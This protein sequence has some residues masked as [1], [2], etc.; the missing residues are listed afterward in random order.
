VVK[1]WPGTGVDVF[2]YTYGSTQ[3]SSEYQGQ[4]AEIRARYGAYR[5]WLQID[6][7]DEVKKDFSKPLKHS[8][9]G[10]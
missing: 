8:V 6:V 1:S 7:L 9:V 2:I 3:D 4:E 5:K 10:N